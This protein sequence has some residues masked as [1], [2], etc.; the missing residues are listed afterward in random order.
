MVRVVPSYLLQLGV[1]V[2]LQIAVLA[3]VGEHLRRQIQG[4]R[5]EL[6][7]TSIV[8]SPE[9]VAGLGVR[10]VEQGE[11]AL[12]LR[13]E[14]GLVLD[15]LRQQVEIALARQEFVITEVEELGHELP[16]LI[17]LFLAQPSI[18]E[19]R[20]DVEG[21]REGLESLGPG[22]LVLFTE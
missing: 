6:S 7:L 9:E 17:T 4:R 5:L 3:P 10:V 20:V 11:D 12:L 14:F 15:L 2:H 8:V 19:V 18:R 16:K 1:E 22:V 21:A 13:S